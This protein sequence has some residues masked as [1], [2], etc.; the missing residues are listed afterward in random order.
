MIKIINIIFFSLAFNFCFAQ[1]WVQ[2]NNNPL[3]SSGRTDNSGFSINGTGYILGGSDANIYYGTEAWAYDTTAKSWSAIAPYP[4]SGGADGKV[5]VAVDSLGYA[6]L[7]VSGGYTWSNSWYSYSPTL[8]KWTTLTPFPGT[9]RAY[10]T[11]FTINGEIYVTGGVNGTNTNGYKDFWK[12][13][14]PTDKWTYLGNCPALGVN[15][16]PVSFAINGMGYLGTGGS[17]DSLT[18][19]ITPQQDFWQYNPTNNTWLSMT[20]F[21]GGP[22]M[23]AMAWATCDKGYVGG[24][25][26]THTPQTLD[27]DF[28]EYNPVNN[29]WTQIANYG[30][31]NLNGA[32]TFVIGQTGYVCGGQRDSAN[33]NQARGYTWANDDWTYTAVYTPGFTLGNSTTPTICSG[34]TISFTDTS[35]YTPTNWFWQFP[36]GKPD[37]SSS[38]N[39]T[40]EYDSTGTFNVIL[41]AWNSCDSGSQTFTK[42]VTVGAGPKVTVTPDSP[43]VCNGQTITLVASGAASYQWVS[44]TDTTD[45]ITITPSKDTTYELL[46]SNGMCSVDTLIRVKVNASAALNVLPQAPFV[47]GGNGITLSGNGNPGDTYSWTPGT[48]LSATTGD[49]VIA[50]PTATITYTV[51][52]TAP[53]GCSDTGTDVIT[54]IPAPNKP[55]VTVSI[56]GDSLISSASSGNQW[57]F[58]GNPITDSTRRY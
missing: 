51:I 55:T 29:S 49:S 47:C 9:S 20:P 4:N 50:S 30:G 12:Y 17:A 39:I 58:D 8:N 38:K 22:R 25:Y 18:N 27:S 13:D 16:Y 32:A 5:A 31:G 52:A 53:G 19:T 44:T 33:Y 10:G 57:N 46:A 45:S 28:Y 2:I 41:S 7:G 3:T 34:Q 35:N 40:I 15:F 54:I 48:G 36:G 11:A 56:T 23:Q 42:Y 43:S 1:S 14:P 21:P 26:E 37:T 24:G 6:G